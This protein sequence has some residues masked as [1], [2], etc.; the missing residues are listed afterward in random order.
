MQRAPCYAISCQHLGM[1]IVCVRLLP[2]ACLIKV[3][4]ANS[5]NAIVLTALGGDT[6]VLYAVEQTGTAQIE[7]VQ[8]SSS[9]ASHLNAVDMLPTVY[10]Y[11]VST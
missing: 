4:E 2:D 5:I 8:G 7:G 11:H 3:M 9:R 1:R 10:E 6:D